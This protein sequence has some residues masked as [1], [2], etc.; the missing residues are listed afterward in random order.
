[1]STT[2]GLAVPWWHRGVIYEI[3]VRSFYDANGDGVGDLAGIAQKLDHLCELGADAFWIT[4]FYPSPMADHGYDVANYVGVDPLF[5]TLADFDA[6]VRAAHARGLKVI[7][8]LVPNH[9]SDEHPWFVESRRSRTSAKR[10]WYLWRDSAPD[11]SVPNNWLSVFGGPAWEWDAA[12]GQY[13]YHAFHRKQPDLNWRNPEVE[14]AMLEVMRFWLERGADGFR[15]DVMWHL[16]KDAEYRDNPPNPLYQPGG[17]PYASILPVYSTDQPEVHEIVRKMRALVDGY[18]ERVL[19]GEIY[20]PVE[21][22]V[23]Y[24]GDRCGAHL[25]LNFQLI[26]LPW[27]APRISA[28]IDVYEASLGE[29]DWPNWVLGNHDQPRVATRLG[30]AQARVAA[31]LLLTLRGTPTLY[32]GDE[33]GMP[34][35]PVPIELAQD[36]QGRNLGLAHSRDPART[37]LRWDAGPT[38]GFTKGVP[39]LPVGAADASSVESQRR[40]PQSMLTLHTRLTA[41]RRDAPALHG[42]RYRP[43]HVDD[44]VFVFQREADGERYAIG[45]NFTSSPCVYAP[46]GVSLRGQVVL[47]THLDREGVRIDGALHLRPDE[48]L[49]VR[50]SSQGPSRS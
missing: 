4:P 14:A 19:I 28:A 45:L 32:Y 36:P 8:D 30:P 47:S 10:D 50:L 3:Y 44:A 49:I 22:L 33:I 6:L 38:A 16:I 43:L 9:T 5:G 34:N 17:S 13:Y 25:P 1:M 24:Y 7:V 42:G 20:L 2:E 29:H 15:V 41:L 37:P 46:E 40:D 26:S 21:Q 39:W 35:V 27:L 12:T 18:G 11:G 48:G 31:M 23:R